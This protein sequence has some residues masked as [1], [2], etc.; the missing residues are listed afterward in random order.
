MCTRPYAGWG[1][2]SGAVRYRTAR[3]VTTAVVFIH[4][5]AADHRIVDGHTQRFRDV[6]NGDTVASV[7]EFV[8]TW[9]G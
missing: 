9:D 3:R 4:P 1:K 6:V 5:C 2:K 8:S 7:S